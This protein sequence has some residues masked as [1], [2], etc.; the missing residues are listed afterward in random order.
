MAHDKVGVSGDG[1][2]WLILNNI[3]IDSTTC[4]GGK[5][6]VSNRYP[7]GLQRPPRAM[8]RDRAWYLGA[9][10]EFGGHAILNLVSPVRLL[11]LDRPA[12]SV[13]KSSTF[14]YDAFVG[15]F[16][17]VA[18]L[19]FVACRF[20]VPSSTIVTLAGE[21]GLTLVL[22]MF[23]LGESVLECS[24][25]PAERSGQVQPRVSAQPYSPRE[26]GVPLPTPRRPLQPARAPRS[27][28]RCPRC[29]IRLFQVNTI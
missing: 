10:G 29:V 8:R 2:E 15:A 24:V 3:Y 25:Y 19:V 28:S 7:T 5:R 9:C 22:M 18:E 20:A 6:A 1:L 21:A 14:T 12:H 27:R 26:T 16:T 17:L 13:S 11:R 23:W 4:S